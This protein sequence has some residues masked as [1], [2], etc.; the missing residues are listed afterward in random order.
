MKLEHIVHLTHDVQPV[1][2]IY[3]FSPYTCTFI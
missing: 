2:L 1:S 3:G